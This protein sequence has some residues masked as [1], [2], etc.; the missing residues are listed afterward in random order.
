MQGPSPKELAI[1]VGN[2]AVFKLLCTRK[3]HNDKKVSP[4]DLNATILPRF[5]STVVPVI[6]QV[7]K[8]LPILP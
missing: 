5:T 8:P 7:T 4:C 6:S 1:I 2:L 3:Y